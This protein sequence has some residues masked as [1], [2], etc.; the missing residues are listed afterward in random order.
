MTADRMWRRM[1][2]ALVIDDEIESAGALAEHLRG[3]DWE[4]HVALSA[5][6]AA[7]TLAARPLDVVVVALRV[8]LALLDA[9]REVDPGLPVIATVACGD[10]EGGLEALRHGALH[11]ARKPLCLDEIAL[12]ADRARAV[13]RLRD[14]N[15]ALA[16]DLAKA[17]AATP[18]L[19]HLRAVLDEYVRFVVD[20]CDG[21][22]AR[23]AAILGP[24]LDGE[25]AR[26]PVYTRAP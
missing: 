22:R 3:R 12:W 9:A 26:A 7:R 11:A 21:D 25:P 4:V 2:V 8:G 24:D 20:A 13:R 10:L 19:P 18:A 5:D 1:G 17:A 6:Q 15:R 14:E 16:R 23:A